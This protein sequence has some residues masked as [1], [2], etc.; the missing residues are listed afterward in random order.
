MI[1]IL[2]LCKE[3]LN[4]TNDFPINHDEFKEFIKKMSEEFELK[5]DLSEF[6]KFENPDHWHIMVLTNEYKQ[7]HLIEMC[8]ETHHHEALLKYY[9]EKKN[10]PIESY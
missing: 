2:P 3:V 5:F 9:K 6:N 1:Q 7:K 4:N 10:K 8:K